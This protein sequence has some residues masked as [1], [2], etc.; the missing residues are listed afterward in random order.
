MNLYEETI[1]TLE[2]NNKKIE[3][4][5]FIETDLNYEWLGL[6]ATENIVEIDIDNFIELAK[7]TNYD[8]GYGGEEIPPTLKIV[9]KDWWIER[10][11]Y[12]GSEW[13]EFK[14][15]PEKPKRKQELTTL[16]DDDLAEI[17]RREE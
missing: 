10:N 13:W 7:K 5:E 17:Y 16:F 15:L 14:T 8:N 12:D 2:K 9:G 4:I 1:K 3:D 6:D 11:S